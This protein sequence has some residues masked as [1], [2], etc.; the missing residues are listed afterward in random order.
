MSA[1]QQ[2]KKWNKYYTGYS[3]KQTGVLKSSHT[4]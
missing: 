3:N 2:Y 1:E 4:I